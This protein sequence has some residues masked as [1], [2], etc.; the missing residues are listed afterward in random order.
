MNLFWVGQKSPDGPLGSGMGTE[1]SAALLPLGEGRA[2]VVERFGKNVT[3]EQAEYRF[4]I[5]GTPVDVR[6]GDIVR[7]PEG[8]LESLQ[9]LGSLELIFRPRA[10]ELEI[11]CFATKTRRTDAFVHPSSYRLKKI[12]VAEMGDEIWIIFNGGYVVYPTELKFE[13]IAAWAIAQAPGF[14]GWE[15]WSNL[16]PSMLEKLKAE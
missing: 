4:A 10:V 7:Q 11:G 3:K 16:Q 2:L 13:E 8:K 1:N 15:F 9:A 6:V 14:E 5:W 12:V